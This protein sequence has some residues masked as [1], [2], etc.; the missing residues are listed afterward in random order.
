MI[1]EKTK[2]FK[3][4][5]GYS[6]ADQVSIRENDLDRAIFA[7]RESVVVDLNGHIIQGRSIIAITPHYHKYTG[8]YDWYEPKDGDDFAQIK[9]D[10]PDFDGIIENHKA[11]VSLLQKQNQISLIGKTDWENNPP[12]IE[13]PKNENKLSEELKSL[14]DKFKV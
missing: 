12:Q 4:K 11:H 1:K 9:R 7:Q 10:C 13:A 5:Y 8:W 6:P 3:I 14:S 2:W